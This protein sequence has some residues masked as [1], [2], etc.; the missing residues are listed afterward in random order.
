MYAFSSSFAIILLRKTF[1]SLP[2]FPYQET[3]KAGS[4]NRKNNFFLNLCMGKSMK[5]ME[6]T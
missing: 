3:A 1:L 5:N 4:R 2:N 6:N